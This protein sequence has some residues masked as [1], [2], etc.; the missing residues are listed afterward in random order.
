MRIRKKGD[1][2]EDRKL[3]EGRKGVGFFLSSFSQP[4]RF[5][6]KEGRKLGERVRRARSMGKHMGV[7]VGRKRRR[8]A[9]Y[10]FK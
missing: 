9:W 6:L 2:E 1:A 7:A 8:G 3:P 10:I 4:I 5:N